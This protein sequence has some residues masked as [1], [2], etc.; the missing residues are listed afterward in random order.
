VNVALACSGLIIT[1]SPT[2]SRVD[3]ASAMSL[4]E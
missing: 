4:K 1:T 2:F 3:K